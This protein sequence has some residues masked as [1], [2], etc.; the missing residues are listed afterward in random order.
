MR[1][2][3]SVVRSEK[4]KAP[5]ALVHFDAVD[6]DLIE[7]RLAASNEERGRAPAAP[8][9]YDGDARD[10]AQGLER[11][12]DLPALDVLAFHHGHRSGDLIE[13]RLEPRGGDD[14]RV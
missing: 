1:S 4:S 2:S 8:G 3:P 12:R 11:V 13:R 14:D 5:P 9:L 7:V 10:V 6:Q